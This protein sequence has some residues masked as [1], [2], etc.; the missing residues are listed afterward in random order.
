[1]AFDTLLIHCHPISADEVS[2]LK[3]LFKT[4]INHSNR[5]DPQTVPDKVLVNVEVMLVQRLP[6]GLVSFSQTPKLKWIQTSMTGLEKI[7]HEPFIRDAAQNSVH[8]RTAAG[9]HTCHI[10]SYIIMTMHALH[11]DL[12]K[13]IMCTQV[14]YFFFLVP[15]CKVA[16]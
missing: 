1:M 3:K 10:P 2:E 9:I 15:T 4:V 8:L 16:L 5:G 12:Q 13:Q 14:R 6:L 11:F 7:L